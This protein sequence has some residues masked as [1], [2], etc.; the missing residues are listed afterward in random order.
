MDK[1]KKIRNII[2]IVLIVGVLV[3]IGIELA[4]RNTEDI[5]NQGHPTVTETPTEIPAKE[6][7][8]TPTVTPT[9]FPVKEAGIPLK[10]FGLDELTEGE[11][12]FIYSVGA[13]GVL[14]SPSG[15]NRISPAGAMINNSFFE[16]GNGARVVTVQKNGEYYRFYNEI[17]GYLC[18]NGTGN[19]AFYSQT[20]TEEADWIIENG[21]GGFYLKNRVAKN[22]NAYPQYLEYYSGVITTY[23][24]N[25]PKSYDIYTFQ[26]YSAG[27]LTGVVNKPMISYGRMSAAEK[28]VEY[29]FRFQIEATYD[30][31]E[32]YV[33]LG[34][35]ALEFTLK[36]GICNV[37]IPAN[38]VQGETLNIQIYGRYFLI[39]YQLKREKIINFREIMYHY[40][41]LQ[42]NT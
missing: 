3:L 12:V 6:P 11:R 8:N 24:M 2:L 10:E 31:K 30:I 19:N 36:N 40:Y 29:E 33:R 42:P 35:E 18:A 38:Q 15:S 27:D 4:K 32:L 9:E 39:L 22:Q 41:T 16:P 28:G 21:N 26:F 7:Q 17:D 20:A 25:N 34:N 14:A 13:K 37:Q 1:A 23:S 5:G